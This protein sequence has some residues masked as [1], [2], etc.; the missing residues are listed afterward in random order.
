MWMILQ[1]L[2]RRAYNDLA[3]RKNG[4]RQIRKSFAGTGTG[5]NDFSAVILNRTRHIKSKT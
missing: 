1:G 4:R 3:A 2:T 5:F